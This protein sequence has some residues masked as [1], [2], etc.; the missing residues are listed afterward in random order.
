MSIEIIKG[1]LLD[2]PEQYIA[3]QCN[4]VSVGS[5]AGLAKAIFDRYPYANIYENRENPDVPGTIIIKGNGQDQRYVIAI[6]GQYYPGGP[7]F[8]GSD[9]YY[10]RLLYFKWG[11]EQI[12][13]IKDLKSIALPFNI[14]CGLANGKWEDYYDMIKTFDHAC[15]YKVKI[16][17][18][19]NES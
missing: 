18:Y 3:H 17:I 10:N 1:D 5:G 4:C 12:S 2:A 19:N 6:L 14:G 16:T 13:K 8:K 11:L 7:A 9:I 15:G